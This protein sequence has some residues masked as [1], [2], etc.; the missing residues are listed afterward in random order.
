[1]DKR[2]KPELAAALADVAKGMSAR[3]AG[4]KHKLS[5]TTITRALI[6]GRGGKPDPMSSA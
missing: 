2:R 6:D 4:R 1:M 5:H 3:A